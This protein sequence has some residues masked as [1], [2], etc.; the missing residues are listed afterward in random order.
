MN[1]LPTPPHWGLL[2]SP[3]F[4][5]STISLSKKPGSHQSSQ[6]KNAIFAPVELLIP[7]FFAELTPPFALCITT[8]LPNRVLYSSQILPDLSF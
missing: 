8:I 7:A 4:N 5:T 6:S 2:T 1:I 3:R